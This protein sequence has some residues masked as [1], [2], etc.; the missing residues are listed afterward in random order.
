MKRPP[1]YWGMAPINRAIVSS[2]GVIKSAI[3]VF[4][5]SPP[6]INNSFWA[7][8]SYEKKKGKQR[9]SLFSDNRWRDDARR[10]LQIC[11]VLIESVVHLGIR[12]LRNMLMSSALLTN[13]QG[14]WSR[15]R[16]TASSFPFYRLSSNWMQCVFAPLDLFVSLPE[17]L[18]NHTSLF[19]PFSHIFRS[20]FF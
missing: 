13:R 6:I 10:Q 5:F 4:V 20:R 14:R 1:G 18:L 11:G 15:S 17:N 7:A 2:L 3:T 8:P 12:G 16:V 19:N 9:N